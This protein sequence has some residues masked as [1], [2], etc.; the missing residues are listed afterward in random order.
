MLPY[1]GFGGGWSSVRQPRAVCGEDSF[2]PGDAGAVLV[3]CKS[4]PHDSDRIAQRLDVA[5]SVV[6]LVMGG[7][8]SE[9]LHHA[10]ERMAGADRSAKE[11]PGNGD[12]VDGFDRS[13]LRLVLMAG[14]LQELGVEAVPVVSH[15]YRVADV[16][17]KSLQHFDG[18]GR[19]ADVPIGDAGVVRDE[20]GDGAGWTAIAEE[21]IAGHD[22]AVA[23]AGCRDLNNLAVVRRKPGRLQIED[24]EGSSRLN[25]LRND[26]VRPNATAGHTLASSGLNGLV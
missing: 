4:P 23:E 22:R 9:S 7:I 12:G 26:L 6:A 11:P 19:I 8:E 15:D 17:G 3:Q 2:A 24:D 10:V 21:L 16:A 25:P 1:S 14:G 5:T 13:P 20:A 18:T